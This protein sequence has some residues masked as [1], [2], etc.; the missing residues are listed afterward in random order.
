[1]PVIFLEFVICFN[2]SSLHLALYV[3]S[4]SLVTGDTQVN[5]ADLT[6]LCTGNCQISTM[7]SR[8]P[9][10]DFSVDFWAKTVAANSC[11]AWT[12]LKNT[13]LGDGVEQSSL[14]VAGF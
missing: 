10:A 5:T 2:F 1:M 13:T 8:G 14:S 6:E 9:S 3:P 11:Y 7:K 12:D 4:A